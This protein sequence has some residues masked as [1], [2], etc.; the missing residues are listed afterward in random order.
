MCVCMLYV[1]M[2][3]MYVCMYVCMYMCMCMVTV[4]VCMY[5]RGLRMYVYPCVCMYVCMYVLYVLYVCM[6]AQ[7]NVCMYVCMCSVCMYCMY[8]GYVCMYVCMYYVCVVCMYVCMYIY[9]Y[10]VCM[11]ESMR[12][13]RCVRDTASVDASALKTYVCV[14][15]SYISMQASVHACRRTCERYCACTPCGLAYVSSSDN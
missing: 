10:G 4:C 3:C 13:N 12:T 9:A 7:C 2:S 6:Y 1:C 14:I 11:C 15:R 8:V 5:V